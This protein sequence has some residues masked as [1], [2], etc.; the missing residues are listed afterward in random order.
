MTIRESNKKS[1]GIIREE[2]RLLINKIELLLA[3]K[4][5]LVAASEPSLNGRLNLPQK[6]A[7]AG[8]MSTV[9]P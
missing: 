6:A 8:S 5:I 2:I 1:R 9:Q 4:T 7:N 3:P